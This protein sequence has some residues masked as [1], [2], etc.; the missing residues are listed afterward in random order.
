MRD[1]DR[2]ADL[3][4]QRPRQQWWLNLKP[5]AQTMA[6]LSDEL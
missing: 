2:M 1:F 4:L 5:I 3:K 6:K